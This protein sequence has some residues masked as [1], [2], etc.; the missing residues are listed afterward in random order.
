MFLDWLFVY[1]FEKTECSSKKRHQR[2]SFSQH[3]HWASLVFL[4]FRSSE[5]GCLALLFA[6][7][8][9]TSTAWDC[10]VGD[11]L[12]LFCFHFF[13]HHLYRDDL[14]Y[15]FVSETQKSS[16]IQEPV[17][18]LEP[19]VFC[20]RLSAQKA[21]R[22]SGAPSPAPPST[23]EQSVASPKRLEAEKSIGNRHFRGYY[24]RVIWP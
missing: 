4:Y 22:R 17:M 6:T 14:A 23:R 5:M 11:F 19:A 13:N 8:H 9:S 2:S 21:S 1:F 3:A 15:F 10:W 24:F 7:F 16:K 18:P 20:D 12:H